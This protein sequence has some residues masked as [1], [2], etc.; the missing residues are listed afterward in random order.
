MSPLL[1][2]VIRRME[3]GPW[4]PKLKWCWS[5][6]DSLRG[7][8]AMAV[9]G[10]KAAAFISLRMSFTSGLSGMDGDWAG[11]A[12]LKASLGGCGLCTLPGMPGRV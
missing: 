6:E 9:K 10:V 4:L 2:E 1:V 7:V 5:A 8:A 3:G 12:V 11:G